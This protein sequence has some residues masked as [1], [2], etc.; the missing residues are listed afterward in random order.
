MKNFF[1]YIC[2]G[3]C[4]SLVPIDIYVAISNQ[5]PISW[6]A[7]SFCFIGGILILVNSL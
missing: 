7:A 6:V 3:V 1:T 5:N 2:A 4:L